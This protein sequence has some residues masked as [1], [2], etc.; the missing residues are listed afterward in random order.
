MRTL[1]DLIKSAEN[2]LHG[3]AAAPGLVVGKAYIYNKEKIEVQDNLIT[4]V[5]EAINNFNEA[6]AKSKKEL[7]KVFELAKVKIA[8]E[9]A[10]IFEA[11]L[12]IL[13]DPILIETIINR[14]KN[15]KRQPE[16]I[17]H[18]EINKYQELMLLSNESYM[19]E[20]AHDIN[21]IKERIIRNL[22]KKRLQSKITNEVIVVS[23]NLTPADTILFSRCDVRGFVM[24]HGGLTSHAAII[25]RSLNIPA[26]LGTHNATEEIKEGDII[27]VDGFY[28][29]VIINPTEEQL[30]YFNNKIERL[31]KLQSDLNELVDLPAVTKDGREIKL[32][33]N[34]DVTGEIDLVVGNGA[35][36][37]GLYRTEQ[38]IAELGEFPDE[39]E[40]TKIYNNLASRI[41]PDILTIRAF[42]I[43]GDK[44]NLL[45]IKESNPFLGLRGIRFLLE[46]EHLFRIQI[47]A[48]L[49]A[50]CNKNIQFMLPMIT[51]ITEI[52]KSKKLIE[53][54]KKELKKE[55]IPFDNNIKIGI[56]IEVPSAALMAR[57]FATE[58]DFL[59]I[60]TN[61]LI[62]YLLAVDRGNDLVS[63]LY[64]EFDPAVIRT[65][66][67][68]SKEGKKGNVDIS[69]CGEMAADTL[70]VPILVG[71][72]LDSLSVS[73]SVIPYLKRIIRSLEYEKTKKLAAECLSL[74]TETEVADRIKKF[75]EDNK[76]TRTR[77]II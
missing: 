34:V 68:I 40:Q 23:N 42:D 67:Y 36:G 65:I 77:N 17:V 48:V 49:K 76:I 3:I 53:D 21:D 73:P 22:Q 6:L 41:Y 19:Q 2:K 57:E 31:K 26:V 18:N 61:D 69:L 35:K 44:I 64:Q 62:Q 29:Y 50:S 16:F 39:N 24:N 58:V 27:V 72:G 33:A 32:L 56:M 4:N 45:N 75:F 63:Y 37:I 43:G 1:G 5:D 13:D 7:H 15:E 9:R 38:I 60:G 12:M 55:K 74:K 59:S 46:H 47:K 20:R 8:E 10:A 54:C 70:A 28:G 11:Q 66:N 25:S 30:K 71:M 52:S 51:T 14:I